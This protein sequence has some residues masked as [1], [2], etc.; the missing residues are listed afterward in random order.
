MAS[1]LSIMINGDLGKN[2]LVMMV[3]VICNYEENSFR[4]WWVMIFRK[5]SISH[6]FWVVFTISLLNCGVALCYS[7]SWGFQRKITREF[8][9]V[10]MGGKRKRVERAS[11]SKWRSKMEV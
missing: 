1:N 2:I 9:E 11:Y 7:A 5:L 3:S 10:N 8:G 6:G 4:L